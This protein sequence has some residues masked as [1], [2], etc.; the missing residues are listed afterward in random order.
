M[1]YWLLKSEPLEYGFEKLIADGKTTWT[2][3]RNFQ[4]R[5]AIKEMK[6]GDLAFF[7]H[8]GDEK[9][10]VGIAKIATDSYA[11]P[12]DKKWETV[13]VAPVKAVGRPVSLD[14]IRSWPALRQ[15][16]L[17]KQS[18]LSVQ[19]VTEEQWREILRIS[20]TAL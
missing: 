13:D 10:I 2:G 6:A 19:P 20:K 1:K 7:Y 3:V 4:A 11:D 5:N 18:R 8:S 12:T 9:Q 15:M 16:P 17:V 14:E